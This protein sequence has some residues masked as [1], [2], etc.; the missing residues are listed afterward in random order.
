MDAAIRICDVDGNPGDRMGALKNGVEGGS[1]PLS[2]SGRDDCGEWH[3]A[4]HRSPS[5][6]EECPDIA[7]FDK[8]GSKKSAVAMH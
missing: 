2:V 7:A 5:R 1:S 4:R 8:L 3:N 6:E